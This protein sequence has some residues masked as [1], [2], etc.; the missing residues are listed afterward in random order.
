MTTPTIVLAEDDRFLRRAV[1]VALTKRGYRM[2]LATDGIEALDA[3]RQHKPALVLLDML[4][5]RMGGMEVLSALRADS[6]PV[7]SGTRVLILSNSSK[8]F[9]MQSAEALG[10]SGYWIKANLSLHELGERI[11]ALIT[12]APAAPG[13]ESARAPTL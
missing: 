11:Q 9:E 8:E 6:D 4:M 5:P 10:I 1:D 13:T 2:V 3:V 12:E 7:I